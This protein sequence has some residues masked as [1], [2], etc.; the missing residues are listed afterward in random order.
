MKLIGDGA[1]R[2]GS[3]ANDPRTGDAPAGCILRLGLDLNFT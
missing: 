2:I 3:E 1:D